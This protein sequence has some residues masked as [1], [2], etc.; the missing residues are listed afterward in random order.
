MT[1][2]KNGVRVGQRYQNTKGQWFEVI[3]VDGC[4]RVR[5]KFEHNGHERVVPAHA[6]KIGSLSCPSYFVGDKFTDKYGR[7]ATIVKI[8][9]VS[10]ITFQW[11]DGVSRVCQSSVIAKNALIHPEDSN[12]LN[13]EIKVGQVYKTWQGAEVTVVEYNSAADILVRFDEPFEVLM[14][15]TQGN[16]KKG[17]LHNK[18]LP[19]VCGVGIV[20][21][22]VHDNKG[23]MYQTWSGMLKRV[24]DPANFQ[25]ATTYQ[26]CTVRE[27][28]YHLN[29]FK[30][31]FS[32]Q[33]LESD[34]HLDKDLLV[35]GNTVY[36]PEKCVFVPRD[37]NTFLTDRA[38]HRGEWPIGVTYHERILK[39]QASCNV[40]G[41]SVY[42]G[43]F[44]CPEEAF[45]EYK[46]CKE[47]YAK[48]L[49]EK[50]KGRIDEKAYVA[51]MNYVVEITD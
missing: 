12:K 38:R 34:F 48:I 8:D 10:R 40:D 39:W 18:Y 32:T 36:S 2:N 47:N 35:K 6:V 42:I 41:E 3:E 9:T 1:R 45:Y 50:W 20:G 7:I 51:L 23:K 22:S 25:T 49:A 17:H 21:D 27:D 16:L 44:L 26:D 46:K 31:W 11:E 28:W 4:K 19:S 37:I 13:P 15:T 24:Y 29:N 43:V 14:R 5:V 30:E 33:T